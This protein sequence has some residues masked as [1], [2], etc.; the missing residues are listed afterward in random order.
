MSKVFVIKKK[1]L[2][3]SSMDFNAAK[4]LFLSKICSFD[5]RG[6]RCLTIQRQ[7]LKKPSTACMF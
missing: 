4:N 5:F 3:F 7:I 1:S 2:I 6:Y